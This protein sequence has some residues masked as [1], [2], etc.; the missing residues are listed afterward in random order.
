MKLFIVGQ[1]WLADAL[2]RQCADGGLDVVGVSAPSRDDRLFRTAEAMGIA[3]SVHARS[4]EPA[5]VPENVDLILSAGAHCFIGQAARSKATMGAIGYHP[6]LL[7]QHRG[8]DAI[9]WAIHM[10]EPVTGG[11]IYWMDDGAD[12]GDIAIQDWC[13][14]RP[15][16]TAAELWRRDLG[17]MGLRLFALAIDLAARGRLPRRPQCEHTASWEPGFSGRLLSGL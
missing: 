1:K 16:D 13:H 9:R 12:T 14:I 6:S 11:T 8:R 4:L 15:G 7:P 3:A 10:R 2:L 5:V 17:P